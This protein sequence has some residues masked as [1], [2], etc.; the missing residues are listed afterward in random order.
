MERELKDIRK[1]FFE[2]LMQVNSIESMF[3]FQ[4]ELA[5]ELKRCERIQRLNKIEIVKDHIHLLRYFGD[6]LSWFFLHPH[7]I[8]QLSK[9]QKIR[10]FLIDQDKAFEKTIEI[11]EKICKFNLPIIIS[12]LTHCIRIGDIIICS[13]PEL[14][15]IIEC[16]LGK[17]K[18]RF[19]L[20]GRRGRQFSRMKGTTEYLEKGEAKVFGEELTRLCI[21]V[22]SPNS[23]NWDVINTVLNEADKDGYGVYKVSDYEIIGAV[24]GENEYHLFENIKPEDFKFKNPLIGTH[25]RVIEE[26]WPT[27]S[28]PANWKI[29]DRYK[30]PLMEGDIFLI[31]IFD[32]HIFIGYK[33]DRVKIVALDNKINPEMVCSGL[34]GCGVVLE[35]EEKK[36]VLSHNFIARI[37][38]GF[39]K[40]ESVSRIMLEFAEKIYNKNNDIF[41]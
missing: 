38:Y 5:E 20:Q 1:F 33:N 9:N 39:E 12:D 41:Q 34:G 2:K 6:S 31:H 30:F 15:S 21:E 19:K 25:Y 13:D 7:T 26:A 35:I 28:P 32:P 23:F 27:I 36:V 3:N 22:D 10:T 4:I 17:K 8:R 16:K 24:R 11:A 29:E 14:P 18:P 40:V 37:L